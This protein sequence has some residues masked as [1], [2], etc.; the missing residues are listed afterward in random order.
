MSL[1]EREIFLVE[2]DMMT[3]ISVSIIFLQQCFKYFLYKTVYTKSKSKK[4][5][6]MFLYEK[7]TQSEWILK[8]F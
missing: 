3:N 6:N 5:L 4:G 1:S 2:K 7:K 8:R